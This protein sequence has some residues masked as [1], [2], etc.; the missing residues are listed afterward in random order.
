LGV[1]GHFGPFSGPGGG[2]FTSTPGGPSQGA[3]RALW[4]R[5]PDPGVPGSPGRGP[6]SRSR[7]PGLGPWARPRG[8]GT[9]REALDGVPGS[10]TGS[11][12]PARTG[13]YIN[14]SRRGPAVSRR[15]FRGPGVP[16]SPRG[17]PE[18]LFP[19]PA[20]EAGNRPFP[21]PRE[22]R[23]APAGPPPARL[24]VIPLCGVPRAAEQK[25]RAPRLARLQVKERVRSSQGRHEKPYISLKLPHCYR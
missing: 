8:R 4:A 20:Q 7:D 23:A 9:S 1:L 14:P 12:T 15:G 17:L 21:P 25:A 13:F 6:G 24:G 16:G 18:A 19:A 10:R 5:F 22:P 2:G 11:R 3:G